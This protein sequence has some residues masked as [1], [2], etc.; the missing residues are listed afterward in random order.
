MKTVADKLLIK[1]GTALWVSDRE[2]LGRLGPLPGG[3]QPVDAL[4]DA[5][6][7][8][9]FGQDAQSVRDLLTAHRDEL[10]LPAVLWVCY[11]KGNKADSRLRRSRQAPFTP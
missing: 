11:P 4:G 10:G 8:L 5:T 6:V 2:Q 9:V 7:A 3:T 1:P